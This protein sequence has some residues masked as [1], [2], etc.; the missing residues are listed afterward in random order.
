MYVPK[1]FEETRIDLLHGFIRDHPLATLVT[2]TSEGLDA[3]HIPVHLAKEPAPYGTLCGHVARANPMWQN[4]DASIEA[5]AVF[6]G[7]EA[8]ISPYWYASKKDGGRVVPTWNYAVV[9]AYGTIK[10]VDDA[11]WLHAQL[12]K[13]TADNEAGFSEPWRISDAPLE[14]TEKL[15]GAIVGI[16]IVITKL[17]GKWKVSQ[18]QPSANRASLIQ[19]LGAIGL[20]SHQAIAAMVAERGGKSDD[21]KG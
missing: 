13:L 1:Q 20:D 15:M 3:N 2:L 18:N 19:G 7:P 14:F 9:H 4:L 10:V 21:P 5:L 11:D 12:E 8:Y 6:H 17:L 16:E